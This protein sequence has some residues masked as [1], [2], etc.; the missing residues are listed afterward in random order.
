MTIQDGATVSA[1]STGSADAGNIFINAGQQLE[2]SDDASITTQAAKASGGNIDIR[3]IDRIRFVNSTV[4][5]SV[6]A[7]DGKGGNIFIDPNVVILEG[8]EVTAKAVGGAGGNI[9]FVTPLF[10]ADSASLSLLSAK[11]ESGLNGTVL[12]Q[13][14]TSNLSG[15]VGQLVSKTSPPQVLLQN[16][17]VALAGGEQSTFILTGRDTLPSQPGGW[18]SSPVA[19]EHWTGD[20]IEEHALGL[21]VRRVEPRVSSPVMSQVQGT[22]V[23]SL[24]RLTPSGFL[25]RSF[26]DRAL[27]GCRS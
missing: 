23:L 26:A 11:S 17:C 16:R 10:L 5:T 24:R 8:S 2:V 6:L 15:A 3:A 27:T 1:S 19:L 22:D 13:S 21:M 7:E 20:N 9:T 4:S 12:I 25:V 14:P 18:L